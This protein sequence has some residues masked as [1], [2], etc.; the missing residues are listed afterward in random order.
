MLNPQKGVMVR[1]AGIAVAA[2]L[3]LAGTGV[4]GGASAQSANLPRLSSDRVLTIDGYRLLDGL[5]SM[6]VKSGFEALMWFIYGFRIAL[7][8]TSGAY[9]ADGAQWRVC[10][11]AAV[12]HTDLLAAINAELERDPAHWEARKDESVVPLALRALARNWPCP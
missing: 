6:G 5:A 4:P 1:L 7:M 2:T 9:V 12:S 11:P 10:L 8:E 3:T